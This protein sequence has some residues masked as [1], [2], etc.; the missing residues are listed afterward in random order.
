GMLDEAVG[1]ADP[2]VRRRVYELARREKGALD[3][4][5]LPGVTVT[6]TQPS[7][8]HTTDSVAVPYLPDPLATGVV[9]HGL[10]GGQDVQLGWDGPQWHQPRSLRLRL[11]DGP[12][13]PHW[14]QT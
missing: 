1:A 12:G 9:L 3:D 7:V 2:A 6:T 14:D 8:L 13:P 4:P 5:S 10:P 11:T